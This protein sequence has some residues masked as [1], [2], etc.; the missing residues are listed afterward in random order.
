MR[1]LTQ[2][3]DPVRAFV[4]DREICLICENLVAIFTSYLL[5][6]A[7]SVTRERNTVGSDRLHP[8]MISVV[9]VVG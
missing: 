1:Q 8:S 3:P 7:S 5:N 4:Q 9:L 6:N 2:P